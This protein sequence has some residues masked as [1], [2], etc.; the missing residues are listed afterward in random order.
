MAEILDL[1]ALVP[2][3][4]IVK[5]A[6]KEIDVSVIPSGVIL[7]IEKKKSKLRSGGDETF[8]LMLDLVC[9]IC[10]PSFPEIKPQWLI[11][12]TDFNQLQALM[13]FVMAP[14]REKAEKAAAKAGKN[15][16]SPKQ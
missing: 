15:A 10:K 4:R 14:I 9:K 6:G 13:E 3:R 2:E 1:D 5:L 12:R 16:E 11:D 8:D 7:E